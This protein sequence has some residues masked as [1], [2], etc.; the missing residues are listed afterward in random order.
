ME[1]EID[2][3]GKRDRQINRK[4]NNNK[5]IIFAYAPR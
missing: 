2:R 3:Y 4:S 1:R 5:K